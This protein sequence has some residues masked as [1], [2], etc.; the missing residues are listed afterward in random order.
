[1]SRPD[2][3]AIAANIIAHGPSAASLAIALTTAYDR[4][5]DDSINQEEMD[6]LLCHRMDRHVRKVD[7]LTRKIE[8]FA[9][10]LRREMPR[11]D[12]P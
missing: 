3:A 8:E 11:D 4:G 5:R 10:A 9:T 6:V 2:Y 1:M 12:T 7:A